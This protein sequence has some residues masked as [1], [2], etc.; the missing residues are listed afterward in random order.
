MQMW[1]AVL[2]QT[3]SQDPLAIPIP[4]THKRCRQNLKQFFF[5]PIKQ[6]FIVLNLHTWIQ[7]ILIM[8]IPPVSLQIYVFFIFLLLKTTCIR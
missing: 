7:C 5:L 6:Y 3:N 2:L 1:S 8:S 4:T